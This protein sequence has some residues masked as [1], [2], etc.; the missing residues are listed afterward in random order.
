MEEATWILALSLGFFISGPK[1]QLRPHQL[2]RL[3][4]NSS[5][6]VSRAVTFQVMFE[7]LREEIKIVR[8][9]KFHQLHG[10]V[11]RRH[12]SPIN[13]TCEPPEDY[14][15]FIEEFGSCGLYR[16][17]SYWEI[18]VYARPVV[19]DDPKQGRFLKFGGRDPGVACFKL[20][21][22]MRGEAGVYETRGVSG[23]FLSAGSFAEWLERAA[24]GVRRNIKKADWRRIVA[25]PQPFTK[26]E[27]GIVS[28]RR[29]YSWRLLQATSKGEMEFEVT[30]GSSQRLHYLSVGIEA[31]SLD[32]RTALEIGG[33]GPGE[34][35]LVRSSLWRGYH[36][37]KDAISAFE[38]PDPGP[39]DREH[40]FEFLTP[41]S[42]AAARASAEA[43]GRTYRRQRYKNAVGS[44]I[45]LDP[46]ERMLA[47]DKL[48]SEQR[49]AE[50]LAHYLWCFDHGLE[51]C[52]SFVGVRSSFL[53]G[54]VW[55]L[56]HDLG[57]DLGYDPALAALRERRDRCFARMQNGTATPEDVDDFASLNRS[58]HESRRTLEVLDAS[59]RGSAS[60][61]TL[62]H[63]LREYLSRAGRYSD[64]LLAFPPEET[65]ANL[66]ASLQSTC[67]GLRAHLEDRI[68]GR[69][70]ELIEALVAVGEQERAAILCSNLLRSL[71]DKSV[72]R[73]LLACAE[74]LNA[75]QVIEALAP[76]VSEKRR[77]G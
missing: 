3:A 49:D 58:L 51:Q 44:E 60:W 48:V 25:G 8:T 20:D 41:E 47:A 37:E 26:E 30:N 17:R 74:R 73:S 7:W 61:M 27:E 13:W 29:H 65:I 50:A 24:K 39:E 5:C 32:T 62:A 33:V 43:L 16:L 11:V 59:P 63:F 46:S 12:E 76:S 34:T 15:R 54:R 31:G 28:L 53:L 2:H 57:Y 38:L 6:P 75:P 64:L 52:L 77:R 23:L 14:R 35:G 72:R 70:C 71:P 68:L 40:Y 36:N 42:V 22:L 10:S 1:L 69:G 19:M 9:P 56:G 66:S 21:E 45:S 55:E 18:A 67:G 4:L